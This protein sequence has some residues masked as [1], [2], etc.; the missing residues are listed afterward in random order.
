LKQELQHGRITLRRFLLLHTDRGETG[1][2]VETEPRAAAP[3]LRDWLQGW[4]PGVSQGVVEAVAYLNPNEDIHVKDE[5]DSQ[6]LRPAVTIRIDEKLWESGKFR[7]SHVRLHDA[8]GIPAVTDV[9][10]SLARFRFGPDKV[11]YRP[12]VEPGRRPQSFEVLPGRQVTAVENI[13]ARR[14]TCDLVRRG[15]FRAAKDSRRNNLVDL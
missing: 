14:R 3:L 12:P 4:L 8:G 2:W 7:G 6:F 1:R 5:T 11:Q 13:E 15:E 9:L 10:R